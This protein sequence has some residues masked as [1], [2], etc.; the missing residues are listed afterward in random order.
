MEQGDWPPFPQKTAPQA[1]PDQ[2][3]IEYAFDDANRLQE[4]RSAGDVVHFILDNANRPT[5]LQLRNGMVT[6]YSYDD[7]NQLKS[8]NYSN[9]GGPVGDLSYDYDAL[10]RVIHLSGSLVSVNLPAAMSGAVY[11]D[12]NQLT[13]WKRGQLHLR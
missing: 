9:A 4:I 11:N 5:R 3:P 10:G 6:D 13:L 8:I 2:A 7:A 1:P 12:Y